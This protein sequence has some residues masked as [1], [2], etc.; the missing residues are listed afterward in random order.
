MKILVF[1][2][3]CNNALSSI[4]SCSIVIGIG[5]INKIVDIAVVVIRSP[6]AQWR[7]GT[8]GG[9]SSRAFT[10]SVRLSYRITGVNPIGIDIDG[11]R[12]IFSRAEN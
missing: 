5:I 3:V 9:R 10:L 4:P 1:V 12:E 11:G 7:D 6:S 8:R 2:I